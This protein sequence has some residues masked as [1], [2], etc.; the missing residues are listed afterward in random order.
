MS[1]Q[2]Y[3]DDASWNRPVCDF[4]T[5]FEPAFFPMLMGVLDGHPLDQLES[6]PSGDA[7]G[8]V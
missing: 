1:I 6:M 5:N 8:E 4:L 2:L 3:S 7:K